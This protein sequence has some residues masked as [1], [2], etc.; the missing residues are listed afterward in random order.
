MGISRYS[1]LFLSLRRRE[2]DGGCNQDLCAILDAAADTQGSN[3]FGLED[4]PASSDTWDPFGQLALEDSSQA[5]TE[6]PRDDNIDELRAIADMSVADSLALVNMFDTEHHDRAGSLTISSTS[7]GS[8]SRTA[9]TRRDDNT[10]GGTNIGGERLTGT[11]HVI[12]SSDGI[13]S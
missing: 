12:S 8:E 9:R 3:I 7:E 2:R 13:S 5:H 10:A 11:F 4:M 1:F 6:V